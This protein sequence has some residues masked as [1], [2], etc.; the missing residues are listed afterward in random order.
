MN[1]FNQAFQ[2]ASLLGI[3]ICISTGDQ[4]SSDG[5]DDGK[6]HVDFPSSSP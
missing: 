2:A 1:A 5:L 4:G 3:T 6:V